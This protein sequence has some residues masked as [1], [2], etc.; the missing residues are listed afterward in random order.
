M[1]DVIMRIFLMIRI[2]KMIRKKARRYTATYERGAC[3]PDCG[4]ACTSE[5]CNRDVFEAYMAGYRDASEW[6]STNDRLPEDVVEIRKEG[7]YTCTVNP[8]LVKTFDG[9]YAISGR[10]GLL[11]SGWRWC[12]YLGCGEHD[13]MWWREIEAS[14]NNK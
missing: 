6:I 12:G 3:N 11:E 9:Q 14:K 4:V 13:I 8:V 7:D 10:R 1:A 5:F 2:M